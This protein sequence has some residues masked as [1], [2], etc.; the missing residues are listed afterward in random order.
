MN[1]CPHVK[2][3]I[4][5]LLHRLTEEQRTAFEAHLKSCSVC[6][7]ELAI[8]TAVEDELSVELQPGVIE[9]TIMTRLEVQ[10][11]KD[12]RSF[13]LYS[14]RTAVLGIA[15]AIACFVLL[16]YLLKFPLDSLPGLSKHVA[17]FADFFG[18]LATIDPIFLFMGFGYFLLIASSI[19]ALAH[20]RR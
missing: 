3:I 10:K 17:G 1:S 7:H 9:H 6:Q 15:A 18:G 8:E 12:M 2:E 11:D 16:P 13:W 5:Y 4:D 14:Y 19:Y 20:M